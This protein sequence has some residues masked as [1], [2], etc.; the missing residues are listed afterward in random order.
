MAIAGR[1]KEGSVSETFRQAEYAITAREWNAFLAIP[2]IEGTGLYSTLG[3]PP[4]ADPRG[5]G[6]A[7]A[8]AYAYAYAYNDWMHATFTRDNRCIRVVAVLQVQ[9]PQRAAL[10]LRRTVTELGAVGGLIVAAQRRISRSVLRTALRRSPAAGLSNRHP[11]RRPPQPLRHVRPDD[12]VVLRRA[13]DEPCDRTDQHDVR[14]CG[15]RCADEAG[16]TIVTAR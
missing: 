1:F 4:G 15:H 13:P 2:E 8:Y 16:S 11:R 5:G 12:Q 3:L 9:D 14:S 7:H 6:A 10:E